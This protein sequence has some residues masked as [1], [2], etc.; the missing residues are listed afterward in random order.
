MLQ[1]QPPSGLERSLSNG[2]SGGGHGGGVFGNGF[3]P[4]L[5]LQ[6]S[7]SHLSHDLSFGGFGP[8]GGGGGGSGVGGSGDGD[9]L[10]GSASLLDLAG[11]DDLDQF[12]FE[13]SLGFGGDSSA[14]APPLTFMPQSAAQVPF[15][16]ED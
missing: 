13:A 12:T 4:Q 16:M 5:Q 7:G 14:P 15:D 6:R 2:S 1:D 9:A 3:G 8:G 10:M 11:L